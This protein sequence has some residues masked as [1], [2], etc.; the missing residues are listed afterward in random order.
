MADFQGARDAVNRANIRVLIID[1]D[2]SAYTFVTHLLGKAY[3]QIDIDWVS[4]LEQGR[5]ALLANRHDVYLVDYVMGSGDENGVSLLRMARE[6][7]VDAPMLLMTAY[8]TYETDLEAMHLGAMDFLDKK[9][10]TAELLERS[11]RY[12]I[13]RKRVERELKQLHERVAALEQLKTEMIRVTAHDLKNPVSNILLNLELLRRTVA[14]D[15]ENR[16]INAID[17][18]AHKIRSIVSNVL[19]LERLEE[20]YNSVFQPVELNQVI[21]TICLEC[22]QRV[23]AKSLSLDLELPEQRLMVSGDSLLL[24]LAANNLLDNAIKYTPEGGSIRVCLRVEGNQAIYE[25]IDTGPGIPEEKHAKVFRPFFR[26]EESANAPEGSGLGLYLVKSII[27]RHRGTMIFESREGQG[28][29]FG[30]RLPL[31]TGGTTG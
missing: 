21:N 23:S 7:D 13:E 8:G 24:A 1:D 26:V 22:D 20:I 10:L 31:Q 28:S 30:F 12:A 15:T 25:V 3:A 9:S 17:Y 5:A 11:I 19:S 29:T 16:F 18:A 2:P 14:P 6:A 4:D 27:T